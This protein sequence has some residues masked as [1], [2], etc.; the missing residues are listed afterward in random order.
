MTDRPV[1]VRLPEND[2]RVLMALSIV[3][4]TNLAEQ[5]RRAVDEYAQ[6]RRN[7]TTLQQEIAAAR[8]KQADV[9]SPLIP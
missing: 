2:L 6:N 5:I 4:D 7:S 3:D 1:T 8:Q 9:F